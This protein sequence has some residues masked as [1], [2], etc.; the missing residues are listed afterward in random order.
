MLTDS[1]PATVDRQAIHL[2]IDCLDVSALNRWLAFVKWLSA[3][4]HCIAFA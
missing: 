1:F 4:L 3:P 2:G